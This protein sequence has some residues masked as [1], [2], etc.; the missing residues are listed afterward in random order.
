[1][2]ACLLLA[3]LTLLAACDTSAP[4]G[5]LPAV[6]R[7]EMVGETFRISAETEAQAAAADA[8]LASGRVGVILGT[9]VRGDG[10]VNTGYSWHLDPATIEYPDASIELCDARP[11]FVEEDLDYWVDTVGRFCPWSA[12]VVGRED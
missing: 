7:V 4:P 10:G 9:L 6:Y 12:R 2:R 1:M 5:T 11:S 8:A 3:T